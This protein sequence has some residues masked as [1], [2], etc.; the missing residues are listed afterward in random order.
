MAYVPVPKDLT[1]VKSKFLFGLT[2]RQ[3]V[4]FGIGAACGLPVFFLTRGAIG[5]T[6][7]SFS[8]R[9]LRNRSRRSSNS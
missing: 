7:A 3:V 6:L 5:T 4:C 9:S 1:K 8:W 2:K